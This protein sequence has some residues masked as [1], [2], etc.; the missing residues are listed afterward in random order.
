MNCFCSF[1][2]CNSIVWF[3][4][5]FFLSNSFS[6]HL[7]RRDTRG[8]LGIQIT[9]KEWWFWHLLKAA[10]NG[11]RWGCCWVFL[12]DGLNVELQ[13]R[14]SIPFRR[15]TKFKRFNSPKFTRTSIWKPAFQFTFFDSNLSKHCWFY[16]VYFS[17]WPM[18]AWNLI[19]PPA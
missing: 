9:G 15:K 14:S 10:T 17:L 5:V 13:W 3:S 16:F 19:S 6:H 7:K 18:E 11:F 8:G 12:A 4:N 1:L 2:F